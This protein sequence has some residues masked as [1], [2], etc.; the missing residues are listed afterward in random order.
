MPHATSRYT[1]GHNFSSSRGFSILDLILRICSIVK[2]LF[3]QPNCC[4]MVNCFPT[5][6]YLYL[7]TNHFS[8]SF[9]IC[10]SSEIGLHD[11]IMWGSLLGLGIM[12][13][14]ATFQRLEKYVK[15]LIMNSK[16]RWALINFCMVTA[17]IHWIYVY[18]KNK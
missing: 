17:L 4:D 18:A 14:S 1:L 9:E 16:D 6:I 11:D 13:T 3:M 10:G 8:K 7:W 12:P 5:N 15:K 2:C